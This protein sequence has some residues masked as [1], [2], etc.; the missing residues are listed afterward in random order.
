MDVLGELLSRE[1]RVTKQTVAAVREPL[2]RVAASAGPLTRS[3]DPAV[4]T[5]TEQ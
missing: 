5:A 1:R 3:S 4:V 2:A